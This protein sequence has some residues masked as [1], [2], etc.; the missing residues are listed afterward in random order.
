MYTTVT[1]LNKSKRSKI[2]CSKKTEILD[3]Y[4]DAIVLTTHVAKSNDSNK[5]KRLNFES[6]RICMQADR[7]E[8]DEI[9]VYIG[10]YINERREK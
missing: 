9:V 3:R 6:A 5:G 10:R 8:R 2:K 7:I 4:M 1:R